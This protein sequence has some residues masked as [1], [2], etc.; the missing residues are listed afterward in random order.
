ME[1]QSR[2]K[3]IDTAKFLGIVAIYLGHIGYLGKCGN[4]TPYYNEIITFVFWY[5]VP[6][7]FF[8]SGC[9]SN[10]DNEKNYFKYA[11][12]KFKS[13][14]IPLWCFSL[15]SVVVY[16]IFIKFDIR[17][18]SGFLLDILKGNIRNQFIAY[19]LWF[20]SCLFVMEMM[21]K[22][23]KYLKNRILILIICIAIY[24][25]DINYIN[26]TPSMIYNIDSAYYYIIYFGLGYAVY[27]YI[28][29]LFQSK[30]IIIKIACI[31]SGILCLIYAIYLFKGTRILSIFNCVPYLHK[32]YPVITASILIWLNLVI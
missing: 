18:L 11:W 29:K 28:N 3:W 12:K 20:I 6:F 15:L 23:I 8:L 13:L 2:I 9:M 27:P 30:K 32:F 10:Y 26:Q 24:L 22:L 14:I 31:L 25:V 21:F 16:F 17:L 19:P 1:K 7:F 5:H 4:V